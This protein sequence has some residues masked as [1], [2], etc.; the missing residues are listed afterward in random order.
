MLVGP[1]IHLETGE[2]AHVTGIWVTDSR[3]GEQVQVTE[4]RPLP[5]EDRAAL[6]SYLRRIRNIGEASAP[7][8]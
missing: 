2:R 1:L 7:R 4:A 5:P 8:S 6:I 3:Y